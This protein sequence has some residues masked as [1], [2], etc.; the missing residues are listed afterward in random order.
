MYH[1]RQHEG[2][3]QTGNGQILRLFRHVGH[4]LKHRHIVE[5][6]KKVRVY[7]VGMNQI[8]K[9][10]MEAKPTIGTWEK[11]LWGKL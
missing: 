1:V 2:M 10:N 9:S 4:R 5:R 11:E 8:K 3:A 6:E 7:V